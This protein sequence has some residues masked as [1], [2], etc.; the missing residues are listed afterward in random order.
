VSKRRHSVPYRP[1]TDT[2]LAWQNGNAGESNAHRFD[3]DSVP[4]RVR[5]SNV[6]T[7]T[8][9]HV[10]EIQWDTT[11]GGKHALDYLTSWDRSSKPADGAWD[12]CGLGPTICAS[13]STFAIPSD[14]NAPQ[15]TADPA[16]PSTTGRWDGKFTM[17][18]GTITRLGSYVRTGSYTGDSS[19]SKNVKDSLG[20]DDYDGTQSFMF[21]NGSFTLVNSTSLRPD[22]AVQYN[23]QQ[24][25][26]ISFGT[27]N[28]VFTED[29][30]G[31]F[32][33]KGLVCS[34]TLNGGAGKSTW[35]SST[36]TRTSPSLLKR[37]S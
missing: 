20:N 36:S 35:T 11:K 12:A 7:G 4:Y 26:T 16:Y 22:S 14:P 30:N 33:L 15:L 34:A 37:A 5:F 21:N 19:T 9:E 2:A 8:F 29:P 31:G 27:A 10:L 18:G 23:Q 6:S 25:S 1:C 13:P 3:G 32:E 28:Q 17:Y 24:I